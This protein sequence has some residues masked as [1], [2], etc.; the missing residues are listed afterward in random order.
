M[1]GNR[2][3][4]WLKAIDDHF[5]IERR[6]IVLFIDNCP[7]HPKVVELKNIKL[8]FLPPSATSKLRPIDGI[9]KV[10]KQSYRTRLIH[11]Y[12]QEMADTDRKRTLIVQSLHDA[13]LNIAAA[14]EA[15]KP[16]T[17][18]N[19]FKKAGF[20]NNVMLEQEEEPMILQDCPVYSSID[21]DVVPYQTQSIKIDNINNTEDEEDESTPILSN[22]QALSAVNDLKRFIASFNE[23]EDALQKLNYIENLIINNATKSFSQTKMND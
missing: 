5:Q 7:A 2:F 18:Q 3:V 6:R 16:A 22:A 9:I 21:H 23:S 13:I 20:R 10:L 11:S 8:V 4:D 14:W 15:I 1:T 19:C 17:I 12:R